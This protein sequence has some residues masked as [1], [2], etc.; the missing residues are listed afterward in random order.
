MNRNDFRNP[1]IQSG[2]LLLIVFIAISI[3]VSSPA[4]GFFGNIFALITGLFKG[5]MFII[6]LGIGLAFS[7]AV[8]IGI[9]IG[10][11]AIDST[12]KA[13]TMFEQV[14]SAL[15]SFYCTLRSCEE[16][17]QA[18]GEPGPKAEEEGDSNLQEMETV[19]ETASPSVAQESNE[20][21][22]PQN[23]ALDA[24]IGK[25]E[26]QLATTEASLVSMNDKIQSLQ[27]TIDQQQSDSTEIGDRLN[28]LETASIE[29]GDQVVKK[30]EDIAEV[31][32]GIT[33]L[34]NTLQPAIDSIAADIADLKKKTS[35]PEVVSGILSYIDSPEDR[36]T[37]T[38]RTKEAVSRG[39]T[40]A[41]TDEFFKEVLPSK[42]H[43]ALTDHPRLTKDF[44][45]S[46]KKKFE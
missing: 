20:P 1:L 19:T 16:I 2:I 42:V 9:F 14:K 29:F 7:I 23:D 43:Q 10:A 11:I 31:T 26:D 5:V 32:A 28:K 41:Q 33:A 38:E 13:K 27:A 39:M 17:P 46:I 44:I 21:S 18:E 3:V 6:A 12:D 34:E 45:R 8:L 37:L 4:E 36:D 15:V 30:T 22:T 24:K 40:Y 25:I 35:V